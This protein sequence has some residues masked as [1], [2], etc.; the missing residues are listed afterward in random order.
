MTALTLV[1]SPDDGDDPTSE[2]D[3]DELH[4]TTNDDGQVV[5]EYASPRLSEPDRVVPTVDGV[6]VGDTEPH[7]PPVGRREIVPAWMKTKA[8]RRAMAADRAHS[9]AF[10]L[11]RAVPW[12]LVV[13][14]NSRHGIAKMAGGVRRWIVN[15]AEAERLATDREVLKAR[16]D[17]HLS[18]RLAGETKLYRRGVRFRRSVT[19]AVVVIAGVASWR[20]WT[21]AAWPNRIIAV[22]V[23]AGFVGLVGTDFSG[24][25][26]TWQRFT[27][28]R[29]QRPDPGR[30]LH[31]LSKLGVGELSTAIRADPASVDFKGPA[32]RAGAGW[33]ID[34]DLPV[35]VTADEVID[36]RHKLAGNLRRPLSCVWPAAAPEIHEAR[37]SLFVADN[38]MADGGPLPWPLAERG[39]TNLFEPAFVGVDER[40]EPVSVLL[41]FASGI[42]GAVP[43]MGKTWLLRLIGLIAA[44]DYRA[45]LYCFDLK[46]TGDLRPLEPV[47]TVNVVG[48]DPEDI[49]AALVHMRGLRTELRRRAKVIRSLPLE[50][51]PESKVTNELASRPDLGLH[52]I[53][54][55]A[56]EVQIWFEHPDAGK[57]LE[58]IAADLVRRGPALGIMAWLATQRPDVKSIPAPIRDNAIV[59]F[60]LKVLTHQV[61]DMV[62][63]DSTL[64]ATMFSRKDLGV[65]VLAG[66]GDDPRIVK[67]AAVDAPTAR[68]IAERG[69]ALRIAAGWDTDT[70]AEPE[71]PES[72]ID[73]IVRTWNRNTDRMHLVEIVAALHTIAPKE[74]PDVTPDTIRTDPVTR[75]VQV[76]SGK[77]ARHD[78]HG[79]DFRRP[80]LTNGARTVTRKGIHW[81]DITTAQEPDTDHPTKGDTTTD[82]H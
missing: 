3:L 57:E 24:P 22:G 7:A 8:G 79:T 14:G 44:L 53:V 58:E 26:V 59:R 4:H 72:I 5:D 54:L 9:V 28:N 71:T 30:V 36:R 18:N 40:G 13:C 63:A 17:V 69:R 10:W 41:M 11:V 2:F 1:G 82:R 45:E 51:C 20:A 43:R 55:L 15:P 31:A 62:L 80:F 19:T 60:C 33:R 27:G 78:I 76:L 49:D 56:D 25:V 21:D 42:I 75:A 16:G 6:A 74:W 48:D 77:L 39:E 61:S 52:P 67:T 65:A 12:Y 34:F 23:L 37:V 66:E 68:R 47:S 50:V 46:G 73:Q 64:R 70:T 29:P 35:G 32:M 38:A 81:H